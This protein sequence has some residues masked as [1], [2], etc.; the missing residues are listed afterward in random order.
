MVSAQT[1]HL[2]KVVF[3]SG[4]SLST[5]TTV[6]SSRNWIENEIFEIRSPEKQVSKRV[7]VSPTSLVLLIVHAFLGS[8]IRV[9]ATRIPSRVAAPGRTKLIV[10]PCLKKTSLQR[11]PSGTQAP[12]SRFSVGVGCAFTSAAALRPTQVTIQGRSLVFVS[13]FC[14]H[15]DGL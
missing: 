4:K 14:R 8:R 1:R 13:M 10:V 5:L 15:S 7:W 9:P 12:S 2:R 11:A 6:S 3:S